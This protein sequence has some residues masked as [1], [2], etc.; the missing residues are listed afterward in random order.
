MKQFGWQK[1][2]GQTRVFVSSKNVLLICF[3]LFAIATWCYSPFSDS[4]KFHQ[5]AH[6]TSSFRGLSV[7]VQ[8]TC[9]ITA[10]FMS[11]IV[12]EKIEKFQVSMEKKRNRFFFSRKQNA[13]RQG[14]MLVLVKY[15]S[16]TNSRLF[17]NYSKNW[18][19]RAMGNETF[20][21]DGLRGNK[22][23]QIGTYGS[24]ILGKKRNPTV[25]QRQ[26]FN[27]KDV[28]ESEWI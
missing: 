22:S 21:W 8:F 13:R 19:G 11:F 25:K 5:S 26:P 14:G 28:F 4:Q 6:F 1:L 27:N 2:F 17:F 24:K 16:Y 9:R 7:A 20:Y 10:F 3:S 15:F 12:R 18:V 23:Y